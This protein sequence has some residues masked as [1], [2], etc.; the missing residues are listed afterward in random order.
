MRR[1][2][3]PLIPVVALFVGGALIRL[4][5]ALERQRPVIFADEVAPL[6]F[7]RAIAGLG[8]HPTMGVDAPYHMGYAA[9]LAVPAWMFGADSVFRTATV[10]NA[11]LLAASAPLLYLILRDTLRVSRRVAIAAAGVTSLYPAFLLEA[12]FSWSESAVLTSVLLTYVACQR[13]L[14]APSLGRALVF[15]ASTAIAYALHPRLI[16]TLALTPVALYLAHR[17]HGLKARHAALAVGVTAALFVAFKLGNAA[18]TSTLYAATPKRNEGS[19]LAWFVADPGKVV[20]AL[21]ALAG[22]GWYLAVATVG[23]APLGV[24]HLVREVRRDPRRVDLLW[25]VATTVTCLLVTAMF[26]ANAGRVDQRIYGRYAE[27]IVA[28]PLAAGLAS[29]AVRRSVLDKFGAMLVVPGF[30]TGVL[31]LIIGTEKF[32]GRVNP[33]NLLG[34][35]QFHELDKQLRIDQISLVAMAVAVAVIAVRYLLHR[36]GAAL[37]FV[38]VAG[39]FVASANRTHQRIIDPIDGNSRAMPSIPDT[40]PLIEDATG[41]DIDQVDVLFAPG[42][43]RS[44]LLRYQVD[45]PEVELDLHRSTD[46]PRG[47]WVLAPSSWSDGEAAGARLVVPDGE[48]L[49]LWVMPGREQDRLEEAAMLS[50]KDPLAASDL[51]SRITP[52]SR[53]MTVE[54]GGHVTVDLRVENLGGRPWPSNRE[55]AAAGEPIFVRAVWQEAGSQATTRADTHV[56]TRRIY[57]RK[58]LDVA[59]GLETRDREGSAVPSGRYRVR[60]E[61]I[62]YRQGFAVAAEGRPISVE[63]R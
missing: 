28:V 24:L 5:F 52:A 37:A 22:Q 8:G 58:T 41:L 1:A 49:A 42:R 7:A 25:I 51:R 56:L 13:M 47:P 4:H 34:I 60:F 61:L 48:T 20:G 31:L 33:M 26:M 36:P 3:L 35:D 15:G 63:V 32:E 57:P 30:L 54:R 43:Y 55:G 6:L 18:F 19:F 11:L 38:A 44:A 23:L 10:V 12:G 39:L 2:R 9:L 53:S 17:W 14:R 29:L 62:Q 46:L 21:G 59:F 50:G 27:T 45:R 40:I 16:P